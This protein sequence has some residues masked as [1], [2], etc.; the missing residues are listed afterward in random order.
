[1]TI[2]LGRVS[3]R[4]DKER[5]GFWGCF[6]RSTLI[7]QTRTERWRGSEPEGEKRSLSGS[8]PGIH[9]A[10]PQTRRKKKKRLNLF[11][12]KSTSKSGQRLSA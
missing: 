9:L 5:L 2:D 12:G 7:L 11:G 4:L 6:K 8:T 1:M 3:L 10:R